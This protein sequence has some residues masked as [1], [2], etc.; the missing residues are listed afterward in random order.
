MN[1]LTHGAVHPWL[2]FPPA[3][4]AILLAGLGGRMLGRRRR[5]PDAP[6]SATEHLATVQ[7]AI[8]GLMSLMIGFTFSLSLSRFEARRVAVLNEAKAISVA[9]ERAALLPSPRASQADRLLAAYLR[10]R[11]ALGAEGSRP[12]L[13]QR[14]LA[15]SMAI[16]HA[17]WI[18]AIGGPNTIATRPEGLF[19]TALN[20]MDD[21]HQERLAADQN[22]VPGAVYLTL[23][24]LAMLASAYGGFAGGMKGSRGAVSNAVLAV[25][26]TTVITLI[27]DID[28]HGSGFV[29]VSQQPLIDLERPAPAA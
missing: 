13:R 4:C 17:L 24:S 19:V 2:L 22:Q 6:A 7:G 16:Q 27:I 29:S 9:E 10:Q 12:D 1:W 25:A 5:D 3:L 8:T 18:V 11:V 21:R 28:T 20:D 23:Y 26:I 15:T 14:T